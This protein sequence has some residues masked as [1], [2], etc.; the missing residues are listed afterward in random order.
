MA[1]TAPA[2]ASIQELFA[3]ASIVAVARILD[4]RH[5]DC[6]PC[7]QRLKSPA[8]ERRHTHL[9]TSNNNK[10]NGSK[11]ATRSTSL[12]NSNEHL[13][14]TLRAML[15][16]IMNFWPVLMGKSNNVN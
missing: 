16:R 2:Q 8:R 10:G 15:R 6:G 11:R 3:A 9:E 7:P 1:S 12:A 14:A 4:I 13:V 5:Y